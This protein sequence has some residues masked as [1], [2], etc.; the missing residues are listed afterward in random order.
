MFRRHLL[1]A[2]FITFGLFCVGGCS[3]ESAPIAPTTFVE[4]IF[5]ELQDNIQKM[6]VVKKGNLSGYITVVDNVLMPRLNFQKMTASSVGPQWRQATDEQKAALQK[7]FSVLLTRTYAGALSEIGNKKMFVK[8][9]RPGSEDATEVIVKTEIKGGGDPIALDYK[10][11]K[12]ESS[13]RITN[14]NVLGVW[15][16]ESYKPQFAQEIGQ[17]G[18]DGLIKALSERN[19]RNAKL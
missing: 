7:E 19:E 4:N 8:P 17:R 5:V 3:A 11:E 6:P 13:W 9:M 12:F 1:Q 16:V 2:A 18:L 14:V 15:L 10:L